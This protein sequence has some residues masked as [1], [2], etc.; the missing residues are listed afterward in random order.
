MA[1]SK[2]ARKYNIVIN[3]PQECGMDHEV[4]KGQ[5]E[6]LSTVEYWCMGDEI[7]TT[8]GTYHTHVFI[9]SHSPVQFNTVKNVFPPAHIENAYGTAEENRTYIL[10]GGKWATSEK[11][12]STVEGTFEEYG[13]MPSE[14]QEKA[15]T[16]TLVMEMIENGAANA[17]IIRKFPSL[18][19][20]S[21]DLDVLRQTFRKEK[22][23]SENRKVTVSF[24]YGATGTGKTRGI[25]ERHPAG[26]VCRITSYRSG[27]AY[28]DAYDGQ[29]VLVLEEFQGQIP[30]A[31]LLTMLDIYPLMLPARYAD[32]VACYTRV[33]I[34]SNKSLPEIYGN[35]FIASQHRTWMALLRRIDEIIEYSEDGSTRSIDKATLE[36][37]NTKTNKKEHKPWWEAVDK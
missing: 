18:A 19:F 25:Y 24:L 37:G 23:M 31:E 8:T 15:P 20:K 2:Q 29:S 14:K 26:D 10:K 1:R 4:I 16:M 13:T 5:M 32:R 17:E 30:V 9:Y 28:F 36:W 11:A 35:E 34:T 33:Y 12:E 27:G 3:N 21:N 22:Y 6:K 7:A